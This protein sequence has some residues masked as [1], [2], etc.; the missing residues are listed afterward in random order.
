MERTLENDFPKCA[1]VHRP[2][3]SIGLGLGGPMNAGDWGARIFYDEDDDDEDDDDD[4]DDKEE[5]VTR[6]Y[7][8]VNDLIS[9]RLD[10]IDWQIF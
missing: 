3:G 4:D 7:R 6:V 5:G 10:L 8:F 1:P 2:Q 9:L